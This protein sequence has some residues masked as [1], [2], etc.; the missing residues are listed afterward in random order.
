M[1]FLPVSQSSE[2]LSFAPISDADAC[3]AIKRLEPSKSVGLDDIPGFIIKCCSGTFFSILGYIF[4]LSLTQ[5]CFP[6]ARKEAASAPVFK[7]RNH[8]VVSNYRPIYILNDFSKLLPFIIHEHVSHYAKFNPTQHGF[9]RTKSTVTNMVTFLD[10]LTPVVCGQRQ[11][12]ALYFD[13]S[14]AFD[15][16][17][18]NMLLHKS[19]GFS[20]G[21]AVTLST[22]KFMFRVSGTLSLHSQDTCSVPQGS[23]LGPFLFNVFISDLFNSTN[24]KFLISADDLKLPKS[25]TL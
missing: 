24:R 25:L 23:V 12:G 14:N 20:D 3:K 7:R 13:P 16:V 11:A 19:F 21:Y 4:N 15:L 2:F 6:A 1:D 17:P 18:H 9:T 22:Y 10:S 8:A 5:Q